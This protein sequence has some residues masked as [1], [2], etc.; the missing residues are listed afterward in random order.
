ML[1][2]V[3]HKAARQLSSTVLINTPKPALLCLLGDHSHLQ[4]HSDHQTK[5]SVTN[6]RRHRCPPLATVLR[7]PLKLAKLCKTHQVSCGLGFKT[8]WW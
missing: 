6:Q 8:I 7:Q 5:K 1:A 4:Q 2:G 3:T